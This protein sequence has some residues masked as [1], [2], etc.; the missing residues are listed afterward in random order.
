MHVVERTRSQAD[1]YSNEGFLVAWLPQ[2][3]C[4]DTHSPIWAGNS[5]SFPICFSIHLIRF[6][7]YCEN[8]GARS[9]REPC[10]HNNWRV[11]SQFGT[12]RKTS[13]PARHR[14]RETERQTDKHRNRYRQSQPDRQRDRASKPA[15]QT[16]TEKQS[17]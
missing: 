11:F 6:C 8:D 4:T 12:E 5:S 1:Y 14:N 9:V 13:Q 3:V 10:M 15:R 2:E 17:Q 7:T 16:G